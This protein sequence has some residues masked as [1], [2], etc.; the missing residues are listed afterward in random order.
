[1]SNNNDD[2]PQIN[3]SKKTFKDIRQEMVSYMERSYSD[4]YQDFNKSSFGSMMLDLVSMVADQLHF[5]IDLAAA[6]ANPA[7][8]TNA[9]TV[10]QHLQ[11]AN[12]EEATYSEAYVHM[13][14]PAN[15][16]GTG[17]DPDYNEIEIPART[18]IVTEGGNEF[19]TLYDAVASHQN[20]EIIGH[21]M[22]SDN[23]QVEW[24]QSK[25][26]VLIR[27][28]VTREYTVDVGPPVSHRKIL[29]PDP[30]LINVEKIVSTE[31]YTWERVDHLTQKVKLTPVVDPES[32]DSR[33]PSL[34]KPRPVPRR[35]IEEPAPNGGTYV[36]FGNGAATED[37]SKSK[38]DPSPSIFKRA[39]YKNDESTKLDLYEVYS[40]DSLGIAPSNTTLTIT[41]R[42]NTTL[43][44]NAAVGTLTTIMDTNV[45]FRNEQLLDAEKVN[46][47]RNNIQ[48]SNEKPINGKIVTPTVQELKKRHLGKASTQNRAVTLKDYVY[49]IYQMPSGYGAV[50]RATA[51]RDTNDFRTNINIFLITEGANGKLESCSDTLKRNVK[52]HLDNMRM[53]SDTIDIF[54]AYILNIGMDIE[55]FVNPG[56]NPKTFQ[57]ALKSRVYEELMLVPPDIGENF[58]LS[59]LVGFIQSMPE[60][61]RVPLK[62]GIKVKNLVGGQYSSYSYNISSN[63]HWKDTHI[64]IPNDTI[65]E[66]KYVDDIV[67]N[68]RVV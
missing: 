54:D 32:T 14:H 7:T 48:V 22:S 47:I 26:K 15:Q 41:Y 6:E 59:K 66:V 21:L 18:R 60:V 31:G 39:G 28:G 35:F 20:S 45:R 11:L 5:Y 52:T 61:S 24:W 27:S 17:I 53:I 37:Y 25:T 55:V 34:M 46:F 64:I 19:E 16:S 44:P 23:R 38:L 68:V 56:V 12:T 65:W 30:A 43:N 2:T 3:Y 4:T 57:A 13:L 42:A 33:I 40:S 67:A 49:S 58:D 36:T 1:M 29:I 50:K 63:Q 62:D 51:V 8:A 10:V 9:Q